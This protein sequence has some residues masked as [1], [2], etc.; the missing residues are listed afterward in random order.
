MPDHVIKVDG[1]AGPVVPVAGTR[2]DRTRPDRRTDHLAGGIA[3]PGSP[4]WK[5]RPV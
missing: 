3:C 2:G 5:L 4:V 1:P